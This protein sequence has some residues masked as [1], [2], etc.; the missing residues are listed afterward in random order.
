MLFPIIFIPSSSSLLFFLCRSPYS[1]C[2]FSAST[3][4]LLE[5]FPVLMHTDHIPPHHN[6]SH[7]HDSLWDPL[8]LNSPTSITV[9]GFSQL[10]CVRK[11]QRTSVIKE[12]ECRWRNESSRCQHLAS[13]MKQL[14][15]Q[16]RIV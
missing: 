14:H 4:C 13:I 1:A 10:T 3:E 16:Q 11:V 2:I 9:L 12:G 6:S 15:H 5:I 7:F 8:Y